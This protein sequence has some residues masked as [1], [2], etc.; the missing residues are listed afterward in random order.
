MAQFQ[1]TIP[2]LG[3]ITYAFPYVRNSL[4]QMGYVF[5][6][7]SYTDERGWFSLKFN[8]S[9]ND[10]DAE[11]KHTL[12][13]TFQNG[14]CFFDFQKGW[15]MYFSSSESQ[16][17]EQ[18]AGS[19]I[20]AIPPMQPAAPVAVVAQPYPYPV[21]ST[22]SLVERQVMVARC[23]YCGN[24]TPADYSQCTYCGAQDPFCFTSSLLTVQVLPQ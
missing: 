12:N 23:R 11:N 16:V 18:R 6:A 5:C 8:G 2:Y 17:F 14:Y 15:T 24:V 13:V 9:G 22:H 1:K 3:T 20:C 4:M 10:N 7:E 19:A 21:Q